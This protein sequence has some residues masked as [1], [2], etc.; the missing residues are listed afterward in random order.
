MMDAAHSGPAH[1]P[2]QFDARSLDL[3]KRLTLT[4]KLP[5]PENAHD[6]RF[7]DFYRL[8][9]GRHGLEFT[10]KLK[11]LDRETVRIVGYVVGQDVPS[12]GRFILSPIK[13]TMATAADGPA[14]DLPPAVV[15]CRCR[16]DSSASICLPFP[17]PRPL[18]DSQQPD[19]LPGATYPAG[20]PEGPLFRDVLGDFFVTGTTGDFVAAHTAGD[21]PLSASGLGAF[22]FGGTMDNTDVHFT[23]GQ[24]VVGGILP[25]RRLADGS[26]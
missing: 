2:R 15:S 25:R 13:V 10:D 19:P 26:D 24:A 17:C 23:L 6:L 8:P 14:H 4:E 11:S 21:V 3:A 18:T 22:L 12:P 1:A 9:M 20:Y 7:S 5:P 16:P